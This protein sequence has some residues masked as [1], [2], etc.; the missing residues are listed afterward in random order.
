VVTL[1][2]GD[3]FGEMSWLLGARRVAT[4]MAASQPTVCMCLTE[5][6]LESTSCS[7]RF[8]SA[9]LTLAEQ[10]LKARQRRLLERGNSEKMSTSFSLGDGGK[11]ARRRGSG[12]DS[13]G[14]SR[15]HSSRSLAP[16]PHSDSISSDDKASTG[17]SGGGL[18]ASGSSNTDGP[19]GSIGFT[20]GRAAMER[21]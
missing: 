5:S 17:S 1:Y 11:H 18:P 16:R 12:T 7:D 4:V 6:A 10:R 20:P 13:G 2:E 3:C 15:P 21:K 8:R 14:G 19:S 9:L